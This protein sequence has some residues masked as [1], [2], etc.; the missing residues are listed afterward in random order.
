MVSAL[1][2]RRHG[3]RSMRV[4]P[5]WLAIMRLPGSPPAVR[6][7]EVSR[8][9]TQLF[10]SILRTVRFSF[11]VIK[12]AGWERPY[13]TVFISYM[14]PRFRMMLLSEKFNTGQSAK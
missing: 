10:D 3:L 11:P 5:V 14:I 7:L 2:F 6:F 9:L 1:M 12:G 8:R 13:G 4:G